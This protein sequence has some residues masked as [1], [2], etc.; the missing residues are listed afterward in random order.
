MA[1]GKGRGERNM[2]ARVEIE[3]QHKAAA[4]VGSLGPPAALFLLPSESAFRLL[5]IL[6]VG[7]F[8]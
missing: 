2:F 5:Q 4:H 8:V 1:S 3:K 7:Q 6:D